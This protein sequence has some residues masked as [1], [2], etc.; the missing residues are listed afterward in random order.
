MRTKLLVTALTLIIAIS[1]S[2]QINKT[3][4]IMN[5]SAE[6]LSKLDLKT[7]SIVKDFITT[8]QQPNRIICH[9]NTVFLVNS[10]TDD[11]RILDVENDSEYLK[12]IS[13]PTGSN[14]Y[15][16]A[17]VGKDKLYV[18]NYNAGT[19]TVINYSTG[20]TEG[21]IQVGKSPQGITFYGTSSVGSYAYVANTGCG[22]WGV[23]DPGTISV[24]NTLTDSVV[25]TIDVPLNPQDIAVDPEGMLHVI[26]TGDYASVPA[27][28]A[29]IDPFQTPPAVTDTIAVG[30]TPGDITITKQGKAYLVAWGDGTNGF[31]YK[32]DTYTHSISHG[33]EN[34]I[35]IGPNVSRLFYDYDEDVLF[36]PTMKV[37]AGDGSVQKFSVQND[38]ITWISDVVG[39][40]T[41]DIAVAKEISLSDPWADKVVS[42]TKGSDQEFESGFYPDNV[43]GELNKN[44]IKNF[45][46]CG[47]PV[48]E[49]LSLGSGGEII[50]QF[51]D[52][53]I[54]DGTGTD[55]T[56]FGNAI[57]VSDEPG[58]EISR[59]TAIVSVSQD[60]NN[61][62]QF[63][64][65]I[66]ELTGFCGVTPTLDPMSPGDPSVSGGDSFDLSDVGLSWASY[67]KIKD[68][69]DIV[70]DNGIFAID[71]VIAVN[72]QNTGIISD[73]SINIPDD[74]TLDQN[75]PNPFNSETTITFYLKNEKYIDLKIYNS[76]GQEVRTL[77]NGNFTRG[78]HV[79]KW[80]A[81]DN[82]GATVPS[83]IYFYS[84]R[85]G[86]KI[87]TKK[88]IL[89]Y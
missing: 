42:F 38:T 57:P 5:G 50:L 86:R 8:G 26:C 53:K 35:L 15:D 88:M 82:R 76:L 27:C 22:G 2:A 77:A 37:W 9:N 48:D 74:F 32:Y 6:T 89:L 66:S 17:V 39:N 49:F 59:K 67:I 62:Y 46:K 33:E 87:I 65:D 20:E 58:A 47:F 64:Y 12:T 1:G 78:R 36:I 75:F 55:F 52:N 30:G 72:S 81:L 10:G 80:N 60:G 16:I 21:D 51:E 43:L 61:W 23:Y 28:V 13:L 18:S 63:P 54:I 73:N 24:I 14:P 41:Q 25:W 68:S 34:P 79:I 44:I 4:Y 56:I 31:L 83:G 45:V 70:N 85:S 11:I 7:E 71:A 3:I 29:V 69:G 84:L 19:V 40:G